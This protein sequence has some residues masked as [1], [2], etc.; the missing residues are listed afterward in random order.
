MLVL[1]ALENGIEIGIGSVYIR[2]FRSGEV[3]RLSGGFFTVDAD[4]ILQRRISRQTLTISPQRPSDMVYASDG[5]SIND[6]LGM[7][8]S[9][10]DEA[11]A[12]I[13]AATHTRAAW[14]T[15]AAPHQAQC[16]QVVRLFAAR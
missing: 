14:E 2:L 7:V 15:R 16:A 5:L 10:G 11:L 12:K 8:N 6:L 4:C 3:V 9:L 13:A 1:S